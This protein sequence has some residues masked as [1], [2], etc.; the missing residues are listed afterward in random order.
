MVQVPFGAE[1]VV[2][3]L[4]VA[5]VDL[6]VGQEGA[7][8]VRVE[9]IDLEVIVDIAALGRNRRG[10]RRRRSSRGGSSCMAQAILSTLWTACSTRLSPHSQTKLYQLR[11]C[12][13]TSLMPAGR[14]LAG[15][16]GFTG[17]V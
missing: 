15:G 6:A 12:H 1:H 8:A 16:I 3:V 2:G 11:I 14:V 13:S 10:R 7:H 4:V 9:V 5:A 17:L